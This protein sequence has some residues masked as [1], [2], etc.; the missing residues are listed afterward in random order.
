MEQELNTNFFES[1]S[2][3]NLERF[4]SECLCWLFNNNKKITSEWVK[5]IIS[6]KS[7][8]NNL[9]IEIDSIEVFTEVDQIDI[10]LIYKM[11]D[12][13]EEYYGI[14]IE[15]KVKA[16][17]HLIK[18]K[19][20]NLFSNFQEGDE[21][22]QTEYY[23]YRNFANKDISNKNEIVIL[24]LIDVVKPKTSD[25][26]KNKN[27]KEKKYI[28]I[29]KDKLKYV[30]LVPNKIQNIK[31]DLKELVKD[32]DIYDFEK[33]NIWNNEKTEFKNPWETY[34]YIELANFLSNN[35]DKITDSVD[36][37]DNHFFTKNYIDFLKKEFNKSVDLDNYNNNIYGK[38]EYMKFLRAAIYKKLNSEFKEL[39][40]NGKV[41]ANSSKS[42]DPL[43]NIIISKDVF[44]EGFDIKF[45]LGLQVQGITNK[46]YI[47]AGED[48]E[49]TK[50]DEKKK[51]DYQD[52]VEKKLN[53]IRDK[54]NKKFKI[55]FSAKIGLLKENKNVTKTFYSFSFNFEDS[56]LSIEKKV[57]YLSDLVNQIYDI[58]NK[59]SFT[60]TSESNSKL[61]K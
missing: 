4:H 49:T 12:D 11:K 29:T 30:F 7:S 23:Y 46:I 58:Y 31:D 41:E 38:I 60:S 14:I 55:L 3:H 22:S 45:E 26:K 36:L 16:N 2:R 33:L 48:Y 61:S 18:L 57:Y 47:S 59:T 20:T 27:I 1:V 25:K 10:V 35:I 52:K 28:D 32:L 5:E 42:G 6:K 56:K 54:D 24:N 50:F 17:E 34:T 37:P 21:L 39:N 43:F 51:K 53:D 13:N 15:N 9:E 19:K 40:K 8:E 44:L